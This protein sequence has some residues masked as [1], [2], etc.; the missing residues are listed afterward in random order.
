MFLP[1]KSQNQHR[2]VS[3]VSSY[4]TIL[5]GCFSVIL[6]LLACIVQIVIA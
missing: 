5:L 1:L 4:V 3:P 6:M 2:F